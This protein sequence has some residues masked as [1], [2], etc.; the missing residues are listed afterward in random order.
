MACVGPNDTYR[1]TNCI[2]SCNVLCK[3]YKLLWNMKNLWQGFKGNTQDK[4]LYYFVGRYG[5]QKTITPASDGNE[6][7]LLLESYDRFFQ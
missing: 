3:T 2:A 4:K 6:Q 5:G 7:K 1:A